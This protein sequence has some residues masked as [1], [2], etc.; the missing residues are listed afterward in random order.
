MSGLYVYALTR[1][2]LE[3]FDFQG[4]RVE[5]LDVAG[6]SAVVERVVER[7][8][9]SEASLREQHDVLMRLSAALDALLPARF[10]AFVDEAELAQL[11]DAR[12]G[13]IQQALDLVSGR[14][15]MTVR[16]REDTVAAGRP[17]ATPAAV[18]SGTAYLEGRRAAAARPLPSAAAA[19]SAAVAHLVVAERSDRSQGRNA[20]SLYHLVARGDVRQYTAALSSFE[21]PDLTVSGPWPPFAFAPD[22]WS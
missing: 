6:L 13:V 11:L 4:R 15:Q 16:L 12:R 5:C 10:G 22:L 2:P 7:P 14:V 21:S 18:V 3:P 1:G 19:V 20:A 8:K 17:V 9:V